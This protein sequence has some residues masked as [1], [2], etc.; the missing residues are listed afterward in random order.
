[1]YIKNTN[2]SFISL[3]HDAIYLSHYASEKSCADFSPKMHE[4][5]LTA[6]LRPDLL[7]ELTALPQT[8]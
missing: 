1:M 8:S 5:R 3:K 4:K 7:G 6:G 2:L